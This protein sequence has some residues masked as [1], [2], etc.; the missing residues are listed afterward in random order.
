MW[1]FLGTFLLGILKWVVEK[2]AKKKMNDKQFI[3]FIEA[4]QK[5]RIGAGKT[6]NDFDDALAETLA[7]MDEEEK[8]K[9]N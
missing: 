9:N 5:R 8:N 3:E 7:K 4:H 2:A 6:A 1:S